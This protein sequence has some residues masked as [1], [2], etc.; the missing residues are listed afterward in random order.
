M[1]EASAAS[2]SPAVSPGAWAAATR[3]SLELGPAVLSHRVIERLAPQVMPRWRSTP[4]AMP[5]LF[6]LRPA[7]GG[8]LGRRASL[9]RWP[10]C[11]PAL[12]WAC[13]QRLPMDRDRRPTDTPFFPRDLVAK[14]LAA[15]SEQP[16]D[17]ACAASQ[18]PGAPGHRPVAGGAARTICAGAPRGRR[19]QGRPVD[20]N[21]TSSPRST[22][23]PRRL[24]SVLQ[25]Q[26]AG[27]H[28]R[29]R[30]HP[31]GVPAVTRNLLGI[32][33][34]KNAGKTTL[35]E[36]LVEE[37]DGARLPHL[38]RQTCPSCLRHRS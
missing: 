20:A 23:P 31:Q 29:G 15:V 8:R 11:W 9:G 19:A 4:M 6:R 36:R 26:P 1:P 18:R 2:S 14:L 22:F 13:P 12:E 32:V 30:P 35:T 24:R 34:F 25:R 3:A 7:G 10:A 33:G 37:L 16:A 27:R 5:A 17:L 21:A 38:D 28:R